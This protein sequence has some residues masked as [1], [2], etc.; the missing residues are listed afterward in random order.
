MGKKKKR[1]KE[2]KRKKIERKKWYLTCDFS[3]LR[4]CCLPHVFHWYKN[5][6][7]LEKL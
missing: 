5:M 3:T 2:K 1:K 4:I 6:R 7:E